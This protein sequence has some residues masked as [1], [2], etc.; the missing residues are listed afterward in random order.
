MRHAR[1][2]MYSKHAVAGTW[3]CCSDE[4]RC[5]L[6]CIRGPKP[7]SPHQTRKLYSLEGYGP[8]WACLR[9]DGATMWP[10]SIAEVHNLCPPRDRRTSSISDSQ[11]S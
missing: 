6:A 7:A 8:V 11:P 4:V 5:C 9:A 10:T 3:Q 2:E 1:L